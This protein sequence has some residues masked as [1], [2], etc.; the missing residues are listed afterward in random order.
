MKTVLVGSTGF[1]GGNLAASYAFDGLYHST[2]VE[3]AF[4]SRPDLLVYAGLPAEKYLANTDPAADM[5]L[6]E[7]AMKNIRSIGPRALVLISTVDVYKE[8]AGKDE[9]APIDTEG[10]HPYGLNR[11]RLEEWAGENFTDRL[12]LRL[13]GLFGKGLKKNF[14][15]DLRT[16]VPTMLT[17]EKYLETAEKTP[18]IERC[19]A[20]GP[21]GFYKLKPLAAEEQSAL[22]LFFETNDFN[23]LS[24]TDS[25]SVYQ[26]Y[27]L[28]RLWSD[29]CLARRA[30]VCLLNLATQPVSAGEVYKALTGK[31]FRNELAKPP[32]FYDFRTKNAAL[33]GKE[34]GYLMSK[35][36]VLN[37]IKEFIQRG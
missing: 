18:L 28:S 23:A 13:P 20:Q 15:F 1:V 17:K 22:R 33:F 35:T 3:Q 21:G 4:G 32:V 9:G 2:N 10:L 26:F 8:P 14:L 36:D 34:N 30:G 29:I 25:R 12:V 31:E 7:G 11:Y 5:A 27:P 16:L 19:Y 37:E 24:F 6:V